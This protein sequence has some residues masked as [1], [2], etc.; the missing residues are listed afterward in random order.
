MTID[1]DAIGRDVLAVL[2]RHGLEPDSFDV[3]IVLPGATF[4]QL[5]GNHPQ[6]INGRMVGITIHINGLPASVQ[7]I[8]RRDM[9]PDMVMQPPT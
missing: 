3:G 8:R 7:V 1:F 5:L 2:A 6:L 9:H 4:D